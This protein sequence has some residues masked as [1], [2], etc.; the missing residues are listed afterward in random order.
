MSSLEVT[1]NNRYRTIY[2]VDE[3]PG[4]KIWRCR[5]DQTGNLVLIAEIQIGTE[6]ERTTIEA[7]A[8]QIAAFKH[9]FM[10][11][12]TDQFVTEGAYCLVC[13]D[14]GG[15]D[16]DRTLRTRGGPFN[17]TDGMLQ[18]QRLLSAL[19]MLHGM[20]PGLFIGDPTPADLWV[21]ENGT[22]MLT[23]FTL[24]RPIRSLPSPYRAPELSGTNA[25]PNSVSDMYAVGA[26]SYQAFTGW[27]PPTA[28]QLKAGTPLNPPRTLNPSLSVLAEQGLL[29]ALQARAANRY[30]TAREMRV[31]LN[32]AQVMSNRP[33]SFTQEPPP[34]PPVVPP[35][36]APIG[37]QPPVVVAGQ[38]TYP[39]PPGYAPLPPGQYYAPPAPPRRSM[40]TGCI[41]TIAVALTL[42]LGIACIGLALLF[43]PGVRSAIGFNAGPAPI[44]A[45]IPANPSS[46][47]APT[48]AV[49]TSGIEPTEVPIPTLVPIALGDQAIVLDSAKTI[50]Q[51]RELT[52]T[53]LGPVGYSPDGKTIAIGIGSRITLRDGQSLDQIGDLNGHTGRVTALAWSADGSLLATGASDDNDIRVWNTNTRQIRHVLRGHTGWI[54]SL[55]FSP[56]GAI[57]A[58]GSIDLTIRLWDAQSGQLLQTL[59]G[60]TD[61]IGG[62]SFSPDG[63]RLAS[64]SRDGSVRLWDTATGQ[65]V[66]SF[67]FQTGLIDASRRY[68]TTAVA[69]SPDGKTIAIGAT[70]ALIY[71]VAATSGKELHR[72]SGHT[73]WI[74]IRGLA[75]STDGTRLY[76]SGLD[77]T[78]RVWDTQAGTELATLQQHSLDIFAIA[79]SPDN[80]E[81]VSSSD[82]EGVLNVWDLASGNVRGS[83]S[84]GQGII[85]N[86][87]FSP[88]SNIVALTGYNGQVQLRALSNNQTQP[89]TGAASTRPLAFISNKEF[90]AITDQGTIVIANIAS[91][92]TRQLEG[93]KDRPAGVAASRDA[94]FVA[95]SGAGGTVVVWEAATGALVSEL[96]T[97]LSVAPQLA[98]SY[99]GDILAVSGAAS[100]PQIELWDL[101]TKQRI[102]TLDGPTKLISSMSFQPGGTLLAATSIDGSMRIWDVQSGLPVRKTDAQPNQGWYTSVSFSPDGTLLATGTVNGDLQI[103]DV[104]TGQEA[105]AYALRDGIFSVNFSPDGTVLAASTRDG[106]VRLFGRAQG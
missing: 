74:V 8:R 92:E 101:A 9:D 59:Q 42:A 90:V 46:S 1:F 16:L 81:L 17:E 18:L 87:I 49:P 77:A 64:A 105:A 70:D 76:S 14:P 60:H 62:V 88:D 31:A 91:G 51:T 19:E 24:A 79:L 75:F 29:R 11:P 84:V 12:L 36:V 5:D 13:P 97:D 25:E 44:V 3:R 23:P 28:E 106:S 39:P 96:K 30:Q 95:A 48:L 103:W 52:G 47:E 43:I 99:N 104:R 45:P 61:L 40:S 50:T 63:T 27:P 78:I 54:R 93:F 94:K 35:S 86:V 66:T 69:F 41:V 26:L 102:H 89:F 10:L 2:T 53:Q 6:T 100:Q 20:R 55:A 58:S 15:Q 72:L 34:A 80:K 67:A 7:L 37:Y 4:S 32:T 85:T 56:N 68:W 82:E 73:N 38:A 71:I 83:L 57:L 33:N 98:F 65:P 22:W 21:A